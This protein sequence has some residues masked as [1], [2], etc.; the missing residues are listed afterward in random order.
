MR[1]GRTEEEAL[2]TITITP[3]K[4]LGIADRVGS[5][6]VGKDADLVIARGCPMEMTVKASVVFIDGQLIFER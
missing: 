2:Q 1:E 3:A 5:I 4:H 6:E